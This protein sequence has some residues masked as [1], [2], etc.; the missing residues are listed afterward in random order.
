[1]SAEQ[2]PARAITARLVPWLKGLLALG[3]IAFV[4]TRLPWS[5]RLL[6]YPGG[7]AE[8]LA[9]A[10]TIE[11]DWRAAS[12]SF[13]GDEA[14]EVGA[15]F[16]E[17]ARALSYG[18][19]ASFARRALP[20]PETASGSGASSAP[21]FD[22]RPGIASVF[23]G[24]DAVWVALALA[25]FV[26][27]YVCGMT[28]WWRVLRMAG[29]RAR[30]SY[31]FRLTLTGLF[32]NLVMPG[33][34]GGDVVKAVL[35][36][37]QNA[38]RAWEAL[39]TIAMDRFIGLVAL[40]HLA[41]VA[42]LCSGERFAAL[43]W[44]AVGMLAGASALGVVLISPRLRT[45][46]GTDRWLARLPFGAKLQR[47]DRALVAYAGQPR[48]LT[49]CYALSLANHMGA[50]LGVWAL[51]RAFGAAGESAG[52]TPYLSIVPVANSLAAIPLTPGGWGVGELA[53]AKLFD[54]AGFDATI[55][56]AISI[57]FRL[58]QTGIGLA[59]GLVLLAPGGRVDL[60]QVQSEARALEAR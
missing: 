32:F 46:L 16:P 8:A 9:L 58:C 4:A 20:G 51:A 43:H 55:G 29:L 41:G 27:L 47:L 19:R 6:W 31:S 56:V 3:L 44:L 25:F 18:G 42:I 35:V 53:Y 54:V 15:E 26:G 36:A 34:T 30:W 50:I 39:V 21:G 59:S 17:E 24:T 11:G 37:R 40:F 52:W 38:G 45:W 14:L 48:E 33:L 2:P 60:E 23:R 12:V 57:G 49:L 10:G 1:M 28:R 7:A 22:W 5:D 13:V